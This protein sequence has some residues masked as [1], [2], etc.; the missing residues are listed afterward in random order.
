MK[1]QTSASEHRLYSC[2]E[3]DA[4]RLR[5]ESSSGHGLFIERAEKV[6]FT[7]LEENQIFYSSPSLGA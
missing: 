5:P 4:N 6:H 3:Q 1:A 7:D 2:S